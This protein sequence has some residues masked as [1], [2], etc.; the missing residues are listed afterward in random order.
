MRAASRIADANDSVVE[1]SAASTRAD[2]GSD[3]AD[4]EQVIVTV[5]GTQIPRVRT[6][7][8][9]FTN[10]ICASTRATPP[11]QSLRTSIGFASTSPKIQVEVHG[12]FIVLAPAGWPV[13]TTWR[14]QAAS[15]MATMT[16]SRNE[17][18]LFKVPPSTMVDLPTAAE[19]TVAGGLFCQ[20]S[21]LQTRRKL[22]YPAVGGDGPG[23]GQATRG[24]SHPVPE[25]Y[26]IA[27][28]P[29]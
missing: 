6:V 3:A 17:V 9:P 2:A 7:A 28:L 5:L 18:R 8:R 24:V 12:L 1:A 26:I 11:G 15:D 16:V 10:D 27:K 13:F 22:G 4:P 29:A 14:K 19:E 25:N 21:A 23:D 20:G